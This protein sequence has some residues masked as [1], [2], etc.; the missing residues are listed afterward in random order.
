MDGKW[1]PGRALLVHL[2]A[3][4]GFWL[5]TGSKELGNPTWMLKNALHLALFVPPTYAHFALLDRFLA[6]GRWKR[7]LLGL[8]LVL[9][10]GTVL[11]ASFGP[12]LTRPKEGFADPSLF[13]LLLTQIVFLLLTAGV[14]YGVQGLRAEL[15]LREMEARQAQSELALLKHQIHPH[16]LFNTLNNLYALARRHEDPRLAEGLARLARLLR[17]SVEEAQGEQVPLERE[18]EQLRAYVELQ[19]LRFAPGDSVDIRFQVQGDAGTLQ[20][21]PML[22]LPFVENAF[23]HAPSLLQAV[24][25][26][27]GLEI[28]AQGLDFGVE[29]TVNAHRR[30]LDNT[31]G[32]G[33]PN[34]KR[35]LELLYPDRHRLEIREEPGLYRTE[36]HLELA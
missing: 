26:H 10:L 16:F 7:Y 30:S 20:V 14:K 33:L 22:L 21:A 19:R 28:G 18:L 1:K 17:Y 4:I 2:G 35:R 11:L 9:A 8:A 25:I 27:I 29:N 24:R 13:A 12:A 6:R 31:P 36:L 3:W 5:L 32:I 34:V 15:T 23:K